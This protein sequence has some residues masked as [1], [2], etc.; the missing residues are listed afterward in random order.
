MKKKSI[1]LQA[2]WE[3]RSKLLAEGD[4]LNEEGYKL[5]A[6]GYKFN[7][8]AD[9]LCEEAILKAYGN[10]GMKWKGSYECHLETGEVFK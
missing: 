9:K 5:L 3:H 7:E 2:I 1:D 10:I 8:E 4:K 6:E